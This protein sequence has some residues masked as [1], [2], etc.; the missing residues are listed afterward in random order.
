MQGRRFFISFIVRREHQRP[1]INQVLKLSDKSFDSAI[2]AE[3]VDGVNV[4][5]KMTIPERSVSNSKVAK[6]ER[7]HGLGMTHEYQRNIMNRDIDGISD[8][9]VT[10]SIESVLGNA[11]IGPKAGY[12]T[13]KEHK[14]EGKA[15]NTVTPLP[16]NGKVITKEQYLKYTTPKNKP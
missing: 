12:K 6:H 4:R 8:R 9:V 14:D 11:G 15:I 2:Q 5:D 16:N 10:G 1:T 13:S 3:D 7:G